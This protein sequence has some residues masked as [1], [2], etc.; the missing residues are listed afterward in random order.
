MNGVGR[1][2]EF[3]FWVVI[4]LNQCALRVEVGPFLGRQRNKPTSDFCDAVH[5]YS[6][7]L[8]GAIAIK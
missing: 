8:E 7:F 6:S 4:S 5:E 2:V 1:R 3:G